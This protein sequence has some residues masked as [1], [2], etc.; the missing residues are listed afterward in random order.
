MMMMIMMMMM[1]LASP[2]HEE[3]TRRLKFGLNPRPLDSDPD[4]L[5][6]GHCVPH[7]NI[8]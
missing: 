8:V 1:V 2:A 6:H 3:T 7:A 4:S 5:Q